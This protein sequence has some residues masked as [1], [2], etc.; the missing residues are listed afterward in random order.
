MVALGACF[1]VLFVLGAPHLH[2]VREAFNVAELSIQA[3]NKAFGVITY[4]NI[5]HGPPV[6]DYDPQRPP[7]ANEVNKETVAHSML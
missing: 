3:N 6:P 1:F 4:L 7:K 5:C 2:T